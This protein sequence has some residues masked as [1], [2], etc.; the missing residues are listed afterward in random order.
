MKL[1]GARRL[2]AAV[3]RLGDLRRGPDQDVGV[4]DRRHPEFRVGA[5]LHPDVADLVFDRL[6]PRL[7]GQAEE[8]P[9]HGV[10][11]VAYRDVGEAGGKQVG[12]VIACRRMTFRHDTRTLLWLYGG[13][14]GCHPALAPEHGV[15]WHGYSPLP[16]SSSM[17]GRPRLR[18]TRS[19]PS[20]R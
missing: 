2:E 19:S 10:A 7:L 6:V 14:M 12:L 16:F 11:L 18:K 15:L 1:D 5:D 13:V 17:L 9:L 8:R 20:M 4:P 3:E